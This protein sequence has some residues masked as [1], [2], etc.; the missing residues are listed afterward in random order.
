M[1]ETFK[2]IRLY[3]GQE[4]IIRV[5]RKTLRMTSHYLIIKKKGL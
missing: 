3:L 4:H 5:A 2:I 1:Y